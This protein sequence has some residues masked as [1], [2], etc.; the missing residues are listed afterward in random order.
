M[1]LH[2]GAGEGS[3]KSLDCK[4]IQPVNPQGN[5]SW[6]YIGRTDAEAP[7]LWPPDAKNWLL[8]KDP[9]AGKDWRQE[10]KG[11]KEDEM[12]R[13]HHWLDGHEF[14]QIP[15]LVMDR[16]PGV[17]QSMGSQRVIHDWVTELNWF[18]I[19]WAK[20]IIMYRKN[21]L[22]SFTWV[23]FGYLDELRQSVSWN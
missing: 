4:E 23:S 14:E 3:W 10:E 5:Q 7:T 15:G 6:M 16:R 20:G 22:L 11:T 18:P 8:R 9:G 12:V 13:W 1:L 2:C 17:L 19:Q 21:D